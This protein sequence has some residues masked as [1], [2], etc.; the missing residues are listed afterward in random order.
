MIVP[1]F[2][3][4]LVFER[5]AGTCTV[6]CTELPCCMPVSGL[7]MLTSTVSGL[8]AALPMPMFCDVR[9]DLDR[10]AD[11]EVFELADV[12]VRPLEDQPRLV[13]SR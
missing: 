9:F 1:T 2:T 10:R 6:N 3:R 12:Q 13:G 8:A 5:H 4:W 7:P 11:D